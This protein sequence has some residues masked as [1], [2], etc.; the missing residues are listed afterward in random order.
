MPIGILG[1][2]LFALSVHS[3]FDCTHRVVNYRSLDVS[4]PV[5]VGIDVTASPVGAAGQ[6]GA[7]FAWVLSCW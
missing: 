6:D 4:D 3:G 2:L 7:V 1:S 5:A